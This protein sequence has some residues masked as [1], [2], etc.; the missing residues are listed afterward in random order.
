[1]RFYCSEC[2]VMYYVD[3]SPDDAAELIACVADGNP[4]T[5]ILLVNDRPRLAETRVMV[6]ERTL[7]LLTSHKE[8][9]L[10]TFWFT[11]NN[12]SWT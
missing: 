1:M 11:E 10:S 2:A 12:G 7:T 3:E 8:E 9:P 4:E 6:S 5:A